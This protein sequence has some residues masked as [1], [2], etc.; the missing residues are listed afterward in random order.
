MSVRFL[1]PWLRKSTM[2]LALGA[3]I[4]AAEAISTPIQREAY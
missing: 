2:C 3:A 1:D 4:V